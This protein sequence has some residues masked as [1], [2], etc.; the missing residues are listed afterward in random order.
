MRTLQP[1]FLFNSKAPLIFSGFTKNLEFDVGFG[2]NEILALLFYTDVATSCNYTRP[3]KISLRSVVAT[4]KQDGVTKYTV[5]LEL[6]YQVSPQV[7][8]NSPKCR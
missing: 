2:V 8:A 6:A 1:R 3:F 5:Y 7:K 4:E